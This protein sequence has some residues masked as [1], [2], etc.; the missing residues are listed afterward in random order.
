MKDEQIIT[1]EE[2]AENVREALRPI[3][4]E[5]LYEAGILEKKGAWYKVLKYKELPSHVKGKII[6]LKQ[7]TKNN[8]VTETLVRFSKPRKSLEKMFKN[9]DAQS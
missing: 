8:V 2:W 1:A 5:A 9:Y 6:A 4:F 3:D 7:T